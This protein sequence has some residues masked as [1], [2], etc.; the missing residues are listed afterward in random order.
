MKKLFCFDGNEFCNNK[1]IS[2]NIENRHFF[3]I[4][5]QFHATL[6][7]VFYYSKNAKFNS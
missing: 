5:H 3:R 1:Q 7:R 6:E 2:Q 4:K